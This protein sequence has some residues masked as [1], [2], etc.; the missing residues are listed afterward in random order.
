VISIGGLAPAVQGMAKSYGVDKTRVILPKYDVI[1]PKISLK[2]K[3]KY[4]IALNDKIHKVFKANVGGIKCYFI[5]DNEVFNVG[6]N[7]KG[8]PNNIYE[9]TSSSNPDASVKRRWAHFNSHAAD[10]VEKFSKKEKNPVSLVHLHDAQTA[11]V[12]KILKTRHFDAWKE[13]E[14][15]AVVFTFHNNNAPLHYNYAE[16]QESLKEI[17]LP[18][19]PLCAFIDGL[20]N[21]DAVTTV[22][23]QFAKEAQTDLYGKQMERYVKITASKGKLIGIVNGNTSSWNPKTD[24]QLKSWKT[25]NGDTLDLTY[26]PDDTDLAQKTIAI[27]RELTAYLSHHQLGHFDPTKPIFLYVGRYDS[28]QKG[29][30]KLPLIMKEA[31]ENG[32]Q[33][34]CIGVEPDRD[35]I[36]FLEEM[37][38]FAQLRNYQG[39]AVIRDYKRPDGRLYWQQGN[40]ASDTNGVQGFG[41]L[42]RAG[43]DVGIFPSSF[44]PCGLVQLE[45][46]A[47]GIPPAA[48][49]T[50]GFV[51]TIFP[52]GP[53]KNGYLF[54]RSPDWQSE[55]QNHDIRQTIK[56]AAQESQ[57]KLNGL[58]SSNSE[59]QEQ[60]IAQKRVMMRNA[61]NSTWESTFD[62]SMSPIERLKRAYALAIRAKQTRGLIPLDL[63]TLHIA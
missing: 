13:G 20:E 49:A 23:E 40:L 63:H 34:I 55:Q 25:R 4:Q 48:T 6:R 24:A 32:A 18:P 53:N 38:A 51:N 9:T 26:G 17:G 50:G 52:S 16:T 30:G 61:A 43:I 60:S 1:D 35:A 28:Y 62:G 22:S 29:I 33:F 2:E 58:Y 21:A 10:L 57:E 44:E 19:D 8:E 54:A 45:L 46:L 12:P 31:I 59:S 7:N 27:R 56:I 42:L 3:P 14:T 5:E 15:P 47:M 11:L 36:T 37:E 41:S 39:V